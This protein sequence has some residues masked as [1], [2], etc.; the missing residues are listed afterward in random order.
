MQNNLKG[1]HGKA[2]VDYGNYKPIFVPMHIVKKIE[3][4]V[5]CSTIENDLVEE[6]TVLQKFHIAKKT[7]RCDYTVAFNK[8]RWFF[9]SKLLGLKNLF[10]RKK[11]D[12]A[13]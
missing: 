5:E 11:I 8:T 1:I 6:H 12:K 2:E 13:A 9:M 10:S 7:P 4:A 3:A